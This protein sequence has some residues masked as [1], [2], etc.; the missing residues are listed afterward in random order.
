MSP[1]RPRHEWSSRWKTGLLIDAPSDNGKTVGGSAPNSLAVQGEALFVS[2]GNNDMIERIDLRQGGIV[3]KQRIVPSPLVSRL[4]GVGPS[5][6]AVSP[7]GTR[8]YVAESG[9][10]AIAVL[11][12]KTLAGAGPHPDGL[13]SLPR[14]AVARRPAPRLHLFQGFGNGPNAGK[15]IPKSEFLRMR[16][17]ISILDV[18]SDGALRR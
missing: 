2:N 15:N 11:D 5:G 8:L 14:G 18:P 1:I 9:I 3:A 16:G 13:V 12:A 7:D 10:N 6:M 17:V 4:R